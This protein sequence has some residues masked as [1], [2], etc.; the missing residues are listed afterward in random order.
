ME[1]LIEQKER[2]K[3][4]T[5]VNLINILPKELREIHSLRVTTLE[6]EITNLKKKVQEH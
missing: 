5:L 3:F 1:A 2:G 4:E 6:D